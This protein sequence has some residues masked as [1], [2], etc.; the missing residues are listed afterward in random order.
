MLAECSGLDWFN[1]VADRSLGEHNL[2]LKSA[3]ELFKIDADQPV[4]EAFKLMEE[5]HI[6]AVPVV[7]GS[8]SRKIIGN[9]S[10]RD[11]RFLLMEPGVLDNQSDLSVRQMM[12][13]VKRLH[14][15][16]NQGSVSKVIMTPP[17]TC[18]RDET[19][20]N[21]VHTLA[22]YHIHRVYVTEEDGSLAGVVTIRD[23]ISRFVTEP[24][25][26]FGNFFTRVIPSFPSSPEAQPV[27]D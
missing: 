5:H 23:I 16:E 22:D 9:V 3:D 19:L 20:K 10:A 25:N 6:G 2:P 7:E 15:H 12:E 27:C 24:D 13:K 26:Y 11:I 21:V 18:G 14:P 1:H 17:I 8:G 4:L